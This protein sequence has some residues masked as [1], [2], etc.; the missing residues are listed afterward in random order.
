MFLSVSLSLDEQQP[1]NIIE[2]DEVV[3]EG[4]Y[5]SSPDDDERIEVGLKETGMH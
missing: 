4:E 1:L 3:I 5:H 2:M